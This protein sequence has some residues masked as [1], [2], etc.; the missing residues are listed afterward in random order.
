M[1]L[2]TGE[3][4][5][6][7]T[8]EFI[9]EQE[10]EPEIDPEVI[11]IADGRFFHRGKG[12][13][14]AS[15]YVGAGPASAVPATAKPEPKQRKPKAKA[16]DAQPSNG[17]EPQATPEPEQQAAPVDN[18]PAPQMQ[19]NP[20]VT[21]PAKQVVAASPRLEALLKQMAPTKAN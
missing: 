3:L 14:V 10:P 15:Q 6:L 11:K 4:I 12:A 13:F 8:G 1:R 19:A 2:P 5:D 18:P 7:A 21:E 9:D 20:G 16:A 17:H